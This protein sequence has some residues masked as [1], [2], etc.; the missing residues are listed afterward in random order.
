M[1]DFKREWTLDHMI[2]VIW[3]RP[4]SCTG[5]APGF[6]SGWK[7][8]GERRWGSQSDGEIIVW[9]LAKKSMLKHFPDI[10]S[11]MVNSVEFSRDGKLLVSGGADKFARVTDRETGKQ[12]HAFEGHTSLV[13]GASLQ[14]NGRTLASVGAD[15]EVKVWNLV[16]G[17]RAENS[18]L[19]ERDHLHPFH[20]LD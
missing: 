11:D 2:G 1:I 6:R 15:G 16:S 14:A 12:L 18:R 17:D 13:L 8:L 7:T 3:P 5:V 9:D 4:P 20:R 10:H 19:Q